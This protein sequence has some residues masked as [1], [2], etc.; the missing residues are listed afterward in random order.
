KY[1]ILLDGAAD[2]A[3]KL[4]QAYFLFL[5]AGKEWI[6]CVCSVGPPEEVAGSM[7]RVGAGLQSDAG[8]GAGLPSEFGLGILL[9]GEF[10]NGVDRQ[11]R[12]RVAGQ[13]DRIDRALAAERL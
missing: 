9:C 1:S 7:K 5:I 6:P 12:R 11:Q 8:D 13:A 2:G 10:L 3:A 4:L